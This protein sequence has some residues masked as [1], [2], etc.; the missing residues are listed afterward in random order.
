D[1]AWRAALDAK[2]LFE[3]EYRLRGSDGSFTWVLDRGVPVLAADGR[4]LEW[5]GALADI[6]DKRAHE[7]MLAEERSIY[8]TLYRIGR[9]LATEHDEERLLQLVTDEATSLTG[10]EFG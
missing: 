1:R 6:T 8:E 7:K 9:S 2:T 4:V 10:A 5:V 3:V